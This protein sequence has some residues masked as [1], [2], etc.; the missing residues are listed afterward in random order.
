MNIILDM[1][2]YYLLPMCSTAFTVRDFLDRNKEINEDI[3]SFKEVSRRPTALLINLYN[4]SYKYQKQA[5]MTISL[6]IQ[7]LLL[8][9]KAHMCVHIYV[10]RQ[11]VFSV[12]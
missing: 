11:R 3:T 8:R 1:N 5:A 2:W 10:A 12:M 9:Q 6:V 4:L 7:V